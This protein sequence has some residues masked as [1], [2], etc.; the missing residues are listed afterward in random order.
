M[1]LLDYESEPTSNR[2]RAGL[3]HNHFRLVRV[4]P[5]LIAPAIYNDTY[6]HYVTSIDALR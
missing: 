5:F 4:F 3:C 1:W 2:E 6:C